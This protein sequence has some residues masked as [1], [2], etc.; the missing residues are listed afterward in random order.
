M[1]L[2]EGEVEVEAP[3]ADAT[4]GSEVVPQAEPEALD[5]VGVDLA[6]AV[7][8]VVPRPLLAVVVDE[9]R[10]RPRSSRSS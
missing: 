2:V 1:P 3:L 5:R 7:S 10:V 8:V 6:D 9:K 4:E